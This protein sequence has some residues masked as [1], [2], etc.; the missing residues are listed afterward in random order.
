MSDILAPH[1]TLKQR[2]FAVTLTALLLIALAPVVAQA[3]FFFGQ[4]KVQYSNFDWRVM[5][6][7]HFKIYYYEE[8][9]HLAEMGARIAE[10][11]YK[12]L[13]KKFNHEVRRVVP[14]IIYSDPLF[15]SQTNTT[16]GFISEATGGFTEFLK[17]RMVV[18]Y[19]GSYADFDHVIRHELVHVFMLSKLASVQRDQRITRSSLPPLW[20]VEGLAEHWSTSWNTQGDMLVRDMV[21]SG[22]ILGI[23]DFR[24]VWGTFYMYKFGQSVCQFIEEKYGSDKITLIMENWWKSKRF[25]DVV[26]LT[27]GVTLE[28]ISKEWVYSLKKD[29]FPLIAEADMPNHTARKLTHS[30][31]SVK[32]APIMYDNGDGVKEWIVY[33]ADKLGYSSLYM[34]DGS[35]EDSDVRTILKGGRSADF[36]SLHLMRSGIDATDDGLLVFS[37]KASETD[38]LYLMDIGRRKVIRQYRFK[39]LVSIHSPRFSPDGQRIVFSGVD[40]SGK[41]DIFL[42]AVGDTSYQR[43]TDDYYQDL[44]PVFSRSGTEALFSSDR[45]PYGDRGAKDI[46]AYDFASGRLKALTSNKFVDR[47]PE[48]TDSG[49]YFVSNRDG[50]NN[51]YYC[52]TDEVDNREEL[53]ARASQVSDE[54]LDTQAIRED[55][56]SEDSTAQSS[57]EFVQVTDLLTGAFDP[58]ISPANGD[59]IYTGYQNFR[60]QIY[61]QAIDVAGDSEKI[62]PQ[63]FRGKQL[64]SATTANE[65]ASRSAEYWKPGII[66]SESVK[67]NVSYATDYSI[68]IAQ[69]AVSYDPVFGTLGGVQALMTDVLG[70]HAF[71]GFLSNS[72]QTKNDIL[73]SFNVGLS[74][75]NLQ[76]RVNWGFGAF[77]TFR[78]FNNVVDGYY[79]E[80]QIGGYAQLRYPLSRFSRIETSVYARHR[81]KDQFLR[82]VRRR[83][84][85]VSHFVSFVSDNSFWESTGPIDGHRINLTVGATAAVNEGRFNDVVAMADIRNYKRIGRHSAFATRIFAYTSGGIDPRRIYHGGS[86]SFRGFDR[87]QWYVPNV[88]FVSNE[89]RFPLINR[90]LLGLPIGNLGFNSIRGAFFYDTGAAWE[91]DYQGFLGSFGAGLRMGFGGLFAFRFDWSYRHDYRHIDSKPV[92]DFFFG[93]NF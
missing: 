62:A 78:E 59:L 45:G 15:F 68:D 31:F 63:E 42:V 77:H 66:A 73:T 93:W 92:F 13:A 69:S 50:A 12:M 2:I 79:F 87:R 72:A 61:R 11:S 37:S 60:F 21:V 67:S 32:G 35:G 39:D 90:L 10:D 19:I 88:L 22:R 82:G 8:E 75:F 74:Y 81:D 91:N 54:S 17:G 18:P 9:E 84:F 48:P 43:L 3:Q 28:Q 36:E 47:S 85:L 25:R 29:Y 26:Y 51:V 40:R 89:L 53:F 24:Q 5:T 65:G 6:T 7:K 57:E 56:T 44:D 33:K 34:M 64:V 20:F 38:A 83:S 16:P 76:R 49:Y 58:R 1:R 71:Y 41:S 80:R 52:K 46:Y 4:N 86:W 27:L 23:E 70:N 55:S 14:L 30:G